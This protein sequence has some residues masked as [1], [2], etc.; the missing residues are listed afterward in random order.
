MCVYR[1]VA[2]GRALDEPDLR[3]TGDSGVDERFE[4]RQFL[5]PF[6][7]I[8]RGLTHG[9]VGGSVHSLHHLAVGETKGS[10]AQDRED[11]NVRPVTAYEASSDVFRARCRILGGSLVVWCTTRTD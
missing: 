6:E 9:F 11:E 7:Q 3:A 8:G 1:R 10:T 2:P 5:V 4:R